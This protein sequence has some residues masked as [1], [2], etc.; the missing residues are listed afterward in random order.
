M[1]LIHDE[2]QITDS[3]SK[4]E[5]IL[6]IPNERNSDWDDF[7]KIQVTQARCE[8][9]SAFQVGDEVDCDINIR[10]RKWENDKGVENYFNN[11]EAWRIVH[12]EGAR[13]TPPPR[14]TENRPPR[15]AAAKSQPPRPAARAA[16]EET[17]DLPF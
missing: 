13:E 7:V 17:D 2:E 5:F 3:F 16:E 11:V 9:L 14:R 10:G 6:H 15:Q 8:V 4:R 12:A 1:Y